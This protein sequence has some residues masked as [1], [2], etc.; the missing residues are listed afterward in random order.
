[1]WFGLAVVSLISQVLLCVKWSDVAVIDTFYTFLLHFHT[2]SYQT[3]NMS[4]Q[5]APQDHVG[6]LTVNKDGCLCLLFFHCLLFKLA[7][8]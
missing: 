2:L 7:W 5:S 8:F 6:A 4:H 3:H 1:M